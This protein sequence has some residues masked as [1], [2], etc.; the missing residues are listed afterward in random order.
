VRDWSS[1]FTPDAYSA[2]T[3]AIAALVAMGTNVANLQIVKPTGSYWHPG[4]SGR[5]QMGPKN[6]L[7]DFGEIHLGVLK[8]LGVSGRVCAFEVWP[9]NIPSRRK[10]SSKSKGALEISDLMPAHRDFAFIVPDTL[11]ADTLLRAVKGA[12]KTLISDV[13]LFDVYVGKGVEGGFK[14][15][16]LDVTLSPKTNTL[17]DKDIEQVTTK[18]IAQAAKVGAV[19]RG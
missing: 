15:L 5:L 4:R 13:K 11:A 19:L 9:E 3:D 6:I 7:A 2:K 18:I 8:K 14:S 12:D 1:N 17:T 10:K 16:A